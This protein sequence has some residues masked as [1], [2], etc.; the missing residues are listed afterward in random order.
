MNVEKR[1]YRIAAAAAII[2]LIGSVL[3]TVVLSICTFGLHELKRI[4]KT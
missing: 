1:T 4:S 3:S 2:G